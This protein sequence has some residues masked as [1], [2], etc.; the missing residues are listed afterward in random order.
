M[1]CG[2][3]SIRIIIISKVKT[4]ASAKIER[5]NDGEKAAGEWELSISHASARAID[6]T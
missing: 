1:V 3:A 6:N 2:A 4:D 5:V